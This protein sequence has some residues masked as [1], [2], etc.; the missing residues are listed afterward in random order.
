MVLLLCLPHRHQD[1]PHCLRV[2]AP[3]VEVRVVLGVVVQLVSR[4]VTARLPQQ[5]LVGEHEREQEGQLL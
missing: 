3:V 2:Q 1:L 5:L 4:S